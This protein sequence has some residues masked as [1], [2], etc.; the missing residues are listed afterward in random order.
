MRNYKRDSRGRFARVAG[1]V[2][3][4]SRNTHRALRKRKGGF[5]PYR[6]HGLGHHTAGVNGGLSITKNR[7]VSFGVYVRTDSMSGQKKAKKLM[8]AQEFA[9]LAASK[10][11]PTIPGHTDTPGS[12][13]RVV[14]RTQ[15]KLLRK[16][17]GREKKS[18]NKYTRF[19][20]D[21]NSLPTYVVQYNSSHDKAKGSYLRRNRAI[22]TY[23]VS[24]TTGKRTYNYTQKPKKSRPQRRNKNA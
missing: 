20:T 5:V 3:S 2:G 18:G 13:L 16:T 14:K 24:S 4:S 11:V 10:R 22:A 17:I 19:G 9:Q 12:K 1:S 21:R 23:N 6:R 8:Q 7:R 15:N